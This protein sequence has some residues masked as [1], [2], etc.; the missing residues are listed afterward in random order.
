MDVNELTGEWA[1]STL[2]DLGTTIY[3]SE[4]A[5]LMQFSSGN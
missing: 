5:E 3:P 1:L 2:S 4:S